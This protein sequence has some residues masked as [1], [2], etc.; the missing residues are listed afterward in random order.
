M[1]AF[2]LL[3]ILLLLVG[4]GIGIYCMVLFIQLAQRG[5]K[6]LDIYIERNSRGDI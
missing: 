1:M 2:G 6:A 5:I 3:Y 4:I